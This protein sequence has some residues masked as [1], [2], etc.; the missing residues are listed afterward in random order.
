MRIA[1]LIDLFY[2]YQLGGAEKQFYELAV[3]LAKKHEVHVYTLNIEGCPSEEKING[4]YVHRIGYRNS[5]KKRSLSALATYFLKTPY[6]IR[7]IRKYDIVHANQISAMFCFF[8]PFIKKPFVVTIHDLYWDLWKNY[9]RFP[10]YYIGKAVELFWSILRYDKIITVSKSSKAKLERLDFVKKISV[11]PNGIDFSKINK[12]SAKKGNH[13]IYVGRLV[14]YKNV[15]LVI[16]SMKELNKKYPI[17]ELRIIGSGEQE[18]Y[19][20]KLVKELK[21]NVKFL[22]YVTEEEKFRQIKS[23]KAFVSM[24]DVE[25]FGISML[26][27]MACG[28]PVIGKKLKAYEEFCNTKNSLLIDGDDIEKTLIRVL[29][30]ESL[31]KRLSIEGI[32]TAKKFDWDNIVI[33]LE[34]IYKTSLFH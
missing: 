5:I 9:Y 22:G 17:L 30:D 26:E 31:M 28:T 12:V 10:L 15:D 33:D 18:T 11:L 34:K 1:M 2:P 32:K 25:G 13:I 21:V 20:K 23:A 14:N 3:R 19:L 8:K 24:S 27:A 4:I 16:K 29:K 6:L 7:Q